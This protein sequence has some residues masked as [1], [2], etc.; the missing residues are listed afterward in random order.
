MKCC[1]ASSSVSLFYDGIPLDK[2]V[3]HTES[4]HLLYCKFKHRLNLK[5]FNC[6]VSKLNTLSLYQHTSQRES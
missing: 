3:Q 1:S 2:T 4:T 5:M 6:Y